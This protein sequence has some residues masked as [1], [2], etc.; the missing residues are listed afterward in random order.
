MVYRSIGFGVAGWFAASQYVKYTG[1]AEP[2][3]KWP[4]EIIFLSS[5]PVGASAILFA[6]WLSVPAKDAFSFISL[7]TATA[8]ILDGLA[9]VYTPFLYSFQK[10]TPIEGLSAIAFGAGWGMLGAYYVSKNGSYP[11]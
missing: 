3:T 8:L 11:I 7:G 1:L 2:A 4:N 5:I 9:T 6:K 10:A